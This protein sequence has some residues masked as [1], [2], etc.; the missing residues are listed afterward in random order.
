MVIYLI[1]G[2]TKMF[3]FLLLNIIIIIVIIII[4]SSAFDWCRKTFYCVPENQRHTK[5]PSQQFD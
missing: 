5:I 1:N 4:D 2:I 3:L